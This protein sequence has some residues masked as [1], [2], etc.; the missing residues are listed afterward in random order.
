MKSSKAGKL[1]GKRKYSSE[2]DL[3]SESKQKALKKGREKF[4]APPLETIKIG[5]YDSRVTLYDN[6][7]LPDLVK[8][9]KQHNLKAHGKKN[10]LIKVI[11]N[12]L[13][14]GKEETTTSVTALEEI[15]ARIGE[16]I[17]H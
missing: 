2:S 3:E 8:F 6:F 7:N 13:Y 11:L 9:C 5:G 17:D 12:Y 16:D 15:D 14:A 10:D 1:S 4:V